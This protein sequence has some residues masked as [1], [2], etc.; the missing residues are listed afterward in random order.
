M[1]SG[2]GY[3][4]GA[5]FTAG[6]GASVNAAI[7]P[8]AH[9]FSLP[10][11]G[12]MATA[13]LTGVV[14]KPDSTPIEGALVKASGTGPVEASSV[15]PQTYTDA[16]GHYTLVLAAPARYDVT[17]SYAPYDPWKFNVAVTVAGPNTQN[18]VLGPAVSNPS[19]RSFSQTL[20]WG[21]TKTVTTTLSN[22]GY[23]A[24]K[25][26]LVE[27]GSGLLADETPAYPPSNIARIAPRTEAVTLG[28]AGVSNNK[29][30]VP[31]T[32]D[33]PD[34]DDCGRRRERG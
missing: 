17:A 18:F 8:A 25:F 5:L 7:N 6:G 34:R 4:A 22:D 1:G 24:L 30:S 27:A 2:G 10:I 16:T 32:T 12:A 28:S 13:T 21:T 9:E 26:E 15:T 23:S 3:L 14:T 19:P 29:D 20:L 33:A 11:C 31:P